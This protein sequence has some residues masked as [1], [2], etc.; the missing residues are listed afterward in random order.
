MT[1]KLYI[2]WTALYVIFSLKLC[3][4]ISDTIV[5]NFSVFLIAQDNTVDTD[6]KTDHFS[7]SII[8]MSVI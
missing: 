3:P 6:S 7:K 1:S 4:L 2:N 8:E 5:L